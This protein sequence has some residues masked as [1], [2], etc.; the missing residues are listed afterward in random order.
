MPKQEA[1]SL[2]QTIKLESGIE[3]GVHVSPQD[4]QLQWNKG[5]K[6]VDVR[7]STLPT[8]FGEDIACRLLYQDTQCISFQDCG[9]HNNAIRL[10]Q[11]MCQNL[12]GII[13]V[14]GPTGSGKTTT[15]YTLLRHLQVSERGMIVTLEDPVEKHMSG[16]RQSSI[17]EAAGYTFA[18]GLK[19]VLRQ[20]PDIIL[21]GEIRDENTAAI[22]IEAAYTGHLVL[23][24]LHTHDVRSTLLRLKTLGTDPFLLGYALKGIIAQKLTPVVCQCQSRPSEAGCNHCHGTGVVKR[25]LAQEVLNIETPYFDDIFNVESVEELGEYIQKI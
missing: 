3:L 12:A 9:M 8:L 21:V 15:L 19:A 16:I 4:G 13:L 2:I 22:A 23:A 11:K 14:T 18:K 7:V 5:G 24:S 6:S 10:I 25:T 17:N 1:I 20:D